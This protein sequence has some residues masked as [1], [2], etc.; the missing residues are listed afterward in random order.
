MKV[1]KYCLLKMTI[2][3]F[4]YGYMDSDEKYYDESVRFKL[5]WLL[6]KWYTNEC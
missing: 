4:L 1:W 2:E 5:K 6:D 3:W